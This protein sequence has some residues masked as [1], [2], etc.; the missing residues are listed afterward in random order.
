MK[1]FLVSLLVAA[2]SLSAPPLAAH[3]LVNING[4]PQPHS[5]VY[6]RTGYGEP[7]QQGH[8]LEANG[9]PGI[10]LWGPR[11]RNHYGAPAGNGGV[12]LPDGQTAPQQGPDINIQPGSHDQLNAYGNP[13]GARR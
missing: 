8:S 10:T 12:P 7:L 4:Q 6:R 2:A 11:S 5:H 13:P 1:I 9:G 3:D